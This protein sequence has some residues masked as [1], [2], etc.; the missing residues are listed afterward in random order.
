MRYR[1][2]LLSLA[3]RA[4]GELRAK[5]FVNTL[6]MSARK[7]VDLFFVFALGYYC[8]LDESGVGRRRT[9]AASGHLIMPAVQML[10]STL[11]LSGKQA[12]A[13]ACDCYDLAID[14]VS[15]IR[16]Q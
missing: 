5:W 14:D 11:Q 2:K 8:E 1:V 4:A 3:P 7:R 13:N 16:S 10:V 15:F 12:T 6:I 9:N